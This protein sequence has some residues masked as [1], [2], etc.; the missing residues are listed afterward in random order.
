MA[1]SVTLDMRVVQLLHSRLCHD[2]VGPVGAVNNGLELATEVSGELDEEAVE[3][4]RSS[5]VTVSER[6][7]YFRVAFG[8][9]AGAIKT[10]REARALLTPAVIGHKNTLVW[11][12]EEL[13]DDWPY[14]DQALKLLLNMAH[15]GGECLPRGGDIEIFIEPEEGMVRFTVTATG[16]GAR[17]E[18]TLLGAL[19]GET[20]VEELTPRSAQGHLLTKLAEYCGGTIS[21]DYPQ[22]E[23]VAIRAAV[24]LPAAEAMEPDAA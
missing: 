16:T 13:A 21:V 19:L 20:P 1:D 24:A 3:L 17:V 22:D 23:M 14:G 8:Y 7:Q 18:P 9:A 4:V 15:L 12:D 6:L 2:L 10:E 11:P 5:A